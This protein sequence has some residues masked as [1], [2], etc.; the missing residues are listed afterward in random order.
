[1][2]GNREVDQG[3]APARAAGRG[4]GH[5]DR[6][7]R[8]ARAVRYEFLPAA[9]APADDTTSNNNDNDYDNGDHD[10]GAAAAI[11]RPAASR[12]RRLELPQ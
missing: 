5:C 12:H 8:D 9:A 4:V 1:M 6:R 10:N 2:G 3:N 7:V 11:A